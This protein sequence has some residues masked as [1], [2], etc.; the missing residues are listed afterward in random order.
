MRMR[1][2]ITAS[3]AT[4]A[5]LS[6]GMLPALSQEVP[7]TSADVARPG[8]KLPG[9]PKIAVVKVADGFLDPVGVASANDGTGR[10]FVVD[11]SGQDQDR[12]QGRQDQR[13][14]VPRSDEE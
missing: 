4:A 10:I 9:D 7:Q 5:L 8:G 13:Q 2:A 11:A 14:A 1:F 3:T 12:D 6:L